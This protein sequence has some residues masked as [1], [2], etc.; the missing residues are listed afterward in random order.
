MMVALIRMVARGQILGYTLKEELK[1]FPDIG[2]GGM[3]D[4]ERS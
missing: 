4:K 2:D 1:G 3:Q